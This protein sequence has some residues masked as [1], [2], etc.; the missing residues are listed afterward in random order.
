MTWMLGTKLEC[1]M[2]VAERDEDKI[3]V[4]CCHRE[5]VHVRT[6]EKRHMKI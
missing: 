4:E 6:V 1:E 3:N 2:K 5:N